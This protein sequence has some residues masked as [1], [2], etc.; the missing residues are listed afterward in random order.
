MG[1]AG[2]EMCRMWDFGQKT[3]YENI[4]I[5]TGMLDHRHAYIKMAGK[6]IALREKWMPSEFLLEV[7]LSHNPRPALQLKH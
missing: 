2:A 1:A 4:E 3:R 7:C 5:G 6:I